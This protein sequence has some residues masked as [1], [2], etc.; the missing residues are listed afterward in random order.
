MYL[1][2]KSA[3]YKIQEGDASDS[4]FSKAIYICKLEETLSAFRKG[5]LYYS[6]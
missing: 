3:I 5:V 4:P 2:L 6:I 1:A